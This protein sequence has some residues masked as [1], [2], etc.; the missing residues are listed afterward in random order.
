MQIH[1]G[2][3]LAVLALP[4][5]GGAALLGA[6][7]VQDPPAQDPAAV[8]Q[9]VQPT[10]PVR[11][12]FEPAVGLALERSWQ[13]E[14]DLLSESLRLMHGEDG[15]PLPGQMRVRS[16]HVL[17][18]I[19]HFMEFADGRP[20]KLRRTF[21]ECRRDSQMGFREMEGVQPPPPMI[22][23]SPLG[24]GVSVVFQWSP[25]E[26]R[27]GRHYDAS[28]GE[29]ENLIGLEE[30]LDLSALLPPEPVVVGTS[31]NV[32]PTALRQLF[33][34]GGS[35]PYDLPRKK[36]PRLLRTLDSGIGSGLDQTF[37][38]QYAGTFVV[39][40]REVR[41]TEGRREA[42]LTLESDFKVSSDQVEQVQARLGPTE[43]A[44]GMVFQE[45][46]LVLQF[47]GSGELVWDLDGGF[48]R[49][50]SLALEERAKQ[51]LVFVTK[52]GDAVKD[53]QDLQMVGKLGIQMTAQPIEPPPVPT[54]GD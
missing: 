36:D 49:A 14:H 30:D 27:Y 10:E 37:R 21:T 28:E 50:L 8:V 40:L 38:G 5:A 25:E 20:T 39:S 34:P 13:D 18:V 32:E 23:S 9:Q 1:F 17:K 51:R 44:A 11:I 45:A 47:Q 2:T 26:S 3:T 7:I 46:T 22:Q 24:K 52:A 41:E 16:R 43:R 19:D 31:W 48:A 35:L 53:T 29:E 42:V 12:A 4:L 54:G 15:I 6:R 33:A